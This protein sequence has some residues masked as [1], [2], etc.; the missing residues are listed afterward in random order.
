MDVFNEEEELVPIGDVATSLGLTTRT[1]RYWEE[2]GIISSF[3][4]PEGGSRAFTPYM[5]RRIKFIIKLKALGLTIREL[6]LLG[7]AYGDA[8]R[9]DHMIPRLIDMLDSHIN[10]VDEKINELSSLRRE[11]VDYRQ[12]M[13]EKFNLSKQ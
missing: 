4:R 9:T 12:K 7:E 11:I 1:I 10:K 3:Q 2:M 5:I 8:R 13:V 6:Q